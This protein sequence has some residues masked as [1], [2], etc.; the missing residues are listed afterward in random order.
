MGA[1]EVRALFLHQCFLRKGLEKMIANSLNRRYLFT[2]FISGLM[3]F[4]VH[5]LTAVVLEGIFNAHNAGAEKIDI[6]VDFSGQSNSIVM[7][8]DGDGFGQD[9]VNRF[10]SL[11]E[12][13]DLV[14]DPTF[15]GGNGLMRLAFFNLIDSNVVQDDEVGIFQ[16]ISLDPLTSKLKTFRVGRRYF[17]ILVSGGKLNPDNWSEIDAASWKKDKVGKLET[18]SSVT[19]SGRF[20]QRFKLSHDELVN[21]LARYLLPGFT[22]TVRIDGQV[23]APLNLVG[24]VVSDLI[25]ST[26]FGNIIYDIVTGE[27]LSFPVRIFGAKDLIISVPDLVQILPASLRHRIPTVFLRE[28]VL[29]GNIMIPGLKPYRDIG[30]RLKSTFLADDLG[31]QLFDLLG[32]IAAKFPV[33]TLLSVNPVNDVDS[34]L[35]REIVQR[36][37]NAFPPGKFQPPPPVKK[38]SLILQIGRVILLEGGQGQDL[39]PKK[40][41]R[42]TK[43]IKYTIVTPNGGHFLGENGVAERQVVVGRRERV[44]YVA[45][46]DAGH[47]WVRCNS[48]EDPACACDLQVEVRGSKEFTLF[49]LRRDMCPGDLL[50]IVV[51]NYNV[52]DGKLV[53]DLKGAVDGVSFGHPSKAFLG[54]RLELSEDVAIGTVIE[55]SVS[56]ERKPQNVA[57]GC[58]RVVAVPTSSTNDLILQGLRYLVE[59]VG[60]QQ[61]L[62]VLGER[63]DQYDQLVP[64]FLVNLALAKTLGWD[65]GYVRGMILSR[66]VQLHLS[67]RAQEENN[68][69]LVSDVVRNAEQERLMRKL[70]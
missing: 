6:R 30:K 43:R 55:V 33:Q 3:P 58:Y 38:P 59:E 9:E 41:S 2:S 31:S 45:P 36:C 50:T 10:Y 54:S 15:I 44:T 23:V 39:M 62:V 63:L 70:G 34:S 35:L 32:M 18:G 26:N 19:F 47:Y 16:V 20:D 42:M 61:E 1:R 13:P 46:T 49:P 17:E 14:S 8:D 57:V 29:S 25:V 22:T 52:D 12:R 11:N 37:H 53:F 24:N 66:M 60:Q 7:I 51:Q 56:Q 4:G 64:A 27:G 48:V 5:P 21:D 40:A 65:R 69:Q 28:G 68:P 67:R